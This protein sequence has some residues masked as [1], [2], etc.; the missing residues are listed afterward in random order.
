[1]TVSFTGVTWEK[2]R[3]VLRGTKDA[4]Q[5]TLEMQDFPLQI[6]CYL[7]ALCLSLCLQGKGNINYKFQTEKCQECKNWRFQLLSETEAKAFY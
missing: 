1:M 7:D 2:E 5:G 6:Q 3:T 4:L